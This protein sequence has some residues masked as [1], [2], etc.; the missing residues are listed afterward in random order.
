VTRRRS[1]SGPCSCRR[2]T[3]WLS[4]AGQWLLATALWLHM[5]VNS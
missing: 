5:S 1:A 4:S 3:R 2:A